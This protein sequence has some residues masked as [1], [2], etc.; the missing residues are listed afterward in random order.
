MLPKIRTMI[1]ELFS[2]MTRA[3]PAM[4]GGGGGGAGEGGSNASRALYGVDVMFDKTTTGE[5]E[6]AVQPKLLEVTFFPSNNAVCDAYERDP[7]LYRSYNDDVFKCL[8]LG[9]ATGGK[10]EGSGGGFVRI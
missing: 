3:Y 1:N 4:G 9:E 8:F 10:G 6:A 2:G 7:V 5:E